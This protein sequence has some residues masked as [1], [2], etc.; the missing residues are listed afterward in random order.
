MAVEIELKARLDD[1]EPVK[2]RLSGSGIYCRSYQK[3]DSYW[4]RPQTTGP[5]LRVRRERGMNADGT[6]YE[7]VSVTSKVKEI[8]DGIEVNDE[9][10]FTVSDDALFEDLLYC[11]GMDKV[12]RKEKNG[13]AW[14]IAGET[15]G[16]PSVTAELSLVTGLGWFLELEIVLA[17][18]RR[19]EIAESRKRLLALL[20]RLEVPADQIEERPYTV[21]LGEPT[22][23]PP[24]S[25]PAR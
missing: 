5:V 16:L 22:P 11:V 1:F 25:P 20:E 6:T 8:T 3:T 19:E 9:R 7:S 10:E 24:S 17:E 13:W 12:K 4:L 14:I 21:L 18:A 23:V 15:A 2:E